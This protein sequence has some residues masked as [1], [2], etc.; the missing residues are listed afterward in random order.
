MGTP[1]NYNIK[2]SQAATITLGHPYH[3]IINNTYAYIH[4]CPIV[5]AYKHGKHDYTFKVEQILHFNSLS[6]FGLLRCS[7]IYLD[8]FLHSASKSRAIESVNGRT[9]RKVTGKV[10][11]LLKY[12]ESLPM[13]PNKRLVAVGEWSRSGYPTLDL[14][15][16]WKLIVL[17]EATKTNVHLI[18]A[19]FKWMCRLIFLIKP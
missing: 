5:Y 13:L 10:T 7:L 17:R 12:P 14:D 11:L 15:R 8:S 19:E 16:V 18:H 3:S 4:Q 2:W 1:T 6:R 9:K